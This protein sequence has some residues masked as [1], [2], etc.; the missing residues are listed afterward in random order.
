MPEVVKKKTA[1]EGKFIKIEEVFWKDGEGVIHKWEAAERTTGQNVVAIVAITD[2]N[3][4]LLVDE[5]RPPVG[6]EV[7]GLP[8]GLCD[9]R[10]EYIED[11]ARRELE[12]E[13]GYMAGKLIKLFAGPV[14]PGFS[15]ESLTV[16]LAEDLKSS[17][18]KAEEK[19]KVYKI[20]LKRLESWLADKEKIGILV[21][22]KTKAFINY[23]RERIG[24]KN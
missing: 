9:V 21:D 4:V 20:P 18:G 19:I 8:A 22:V 15:S 1:W 2:K 16:Y 11:T 7:I 23:A 17:G 13:T 24:K 14:S 12:E 6:A 5:F 3:E 10:N